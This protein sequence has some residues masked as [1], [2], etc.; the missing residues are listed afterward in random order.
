MAMPTPIW[1]TLFR[2]FVLL[3]CF[4]ASERVGRK[5]AMS[6]AMMPMTTISSMSENAAV[7]LAVSRRRVM[8]TSFWRQAAARVAGDVGAAAD[9]AFYMVGAGCE[10]GKRG[11]D[12]V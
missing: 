12:N 9:G 4:R 1:R 7:R 5:I 6:S 10:R 11:Q 3:A 2:H 8:N